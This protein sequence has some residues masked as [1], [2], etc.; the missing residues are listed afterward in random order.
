MRSCSDGQESTSYELVLCMISS[1]VHF[2]DFLKH[3]EFRSGKVLHEELLSFI[4]CS[5]SQSSSKHFVLETSC[6]VSHSNL[7]VVARFKTRY[8]TNLE[9]FGWYFNHISV[10]RDRSAQASSSCLRNL[11]L[12]VYVFLFTMICENPVP[13]RPKTHAQ[14]CFLLSSEFSE[15]L[16]WFFDLTWNCRSCRLRLPCGLPRAASC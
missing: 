11:V 8:I 6:T 10:L 12:T 13:G 3:F 15:K 16:R 7:R 5:G 14:R 9:D 1:K 4:L 2:W